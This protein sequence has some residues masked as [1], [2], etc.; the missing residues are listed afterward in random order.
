MAEKAG[1][2]A[3]E[4]ILKSSRN[5]GLGAG[6]IGAALVGGYTLMNSI[7]AGFSHYKARV[8]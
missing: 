3:F 6:L 4:K 1:K 5:A 8:Y 2:E 7:F